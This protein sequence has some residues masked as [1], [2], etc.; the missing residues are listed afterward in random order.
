MAPPYFLALRT[1]PQQVSTAPLSL[2]M[3]P[4]SLESQAPRELLLQALE[5]WPADSELSK[6]PGDTRI[7]RICAAPAPKETSWPA[8]SP[9]DSRYSC[10]EY[11]VPRNLV[12]PAGNTETRQP[13]S[14]RSHP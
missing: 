5:A 13:G 8:A 1:L 11:R 6:P 4:V 7:F 10:P 12:L 3:L 9:T 2:Q 14:C